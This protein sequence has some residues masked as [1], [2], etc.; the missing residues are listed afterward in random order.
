MT[1]NSG[2]PADNGN[3]LKKE[4]K[5]GLLVS[6]IGSVLATGGIGW[7][8]DLKLDSVPGWAATAVALAITG[9]IGALTA[10][11]TKN[12]SGRSLR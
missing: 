9:A 11:K 3:G 12:D 4:S 6:Y 10:Y 1:V 2:D 5:Y 7:L 8:T